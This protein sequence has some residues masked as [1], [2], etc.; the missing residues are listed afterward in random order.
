LQWQ[1]QERMLADWKLQLN[2]RHEELEEFHRH[3]QESLSR[4]L[5]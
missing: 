2:D 4:I 1:G 5:K 3:Q